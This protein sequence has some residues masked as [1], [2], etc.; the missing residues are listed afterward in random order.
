MKADPPLIQEAWYRIQGW[1]K[2]A[3]NHTTLPARVTLKRITAE[4]VALY[5]RVP[6]L[7]KNILVQI[8]PLEVEDKV[9]DK[10]EIDWA[11]KRLR[12]NRSGGP[13]WTWAEHLK[14]WLMA[15][16]RGDMGETADNYMGG[17]E[18]TRGGRKTG[19]G[20]LN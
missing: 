7:V 8:E 3:V 18:D 1:Y 4:R 5:S 19:R 10:R 11:V 17:Q 9:S 2:A 14:G 20:S 13:S 12:N 6:P 16:Q 15:T